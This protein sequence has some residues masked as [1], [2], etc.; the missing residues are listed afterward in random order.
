MIGPI[1]LMNLILVLIAAILTLAD[2]FL[3]GGG[4][5]RL[6]VNKERVIKAGSG[7]T[8]MECLTAERIFVPSAC[9]GK[10]TCGQCKIKVISGGGDILPTEEVF[11]TRDEQREHFRLACQVKLKG[12]VEIELPE[13][14]LET[15]E[16]TGRVVSIE[17]L[18]YDIKYLKVA[19]ISPPS[20]EFKPGQYLQI[21]IPGTDEY[22][23]YSVASSPSMHDAVEFNIR[24]VPGGLC[25]TYVHKVLEEGDEVIL[26]GPFGDFYLREDSWRRMVC[27]GGG[28]GMAP[29]RSILLYLAEQG[30]PREVMY[31]FGA[32]SARDLFYTDELKALENK[33]PNFK[34]I[35]A[36]SEPR[37]CDN[38]S[39]EVG[40]ITD[41][42]SKYLDRLEDAEAYLCG[43]PPMIDAAIAF[44]TRK[45]MDERHIYYDKF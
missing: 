14:L 8:L 9:G 27:I 16:Y 24:L 20:I 5:A 33:F 29:I 21:K 25:S 36:L 3:I 41:V 38:W 10:A 18:T 4:E 37:D 15:K 13:Y 31:F 42:A 32:R 39:G 2:K 11:I 17:P 6:I 19:L 22:R 26:T 44:L 12:D 7:A 40:L 35:P 34:Y 43:P 1:L 30:M 45:G 28:C 23:A